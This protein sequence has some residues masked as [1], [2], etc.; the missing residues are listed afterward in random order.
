[1]KHHENGLPPGIEGAIKHILK[2]R[3]KGTIENDCSFDE[4]DLAQDLRLKYLENQQ[5]LRNGNPKA[6]SPIILSGERQGE[7]N[8]NA[9]NHW[10]KQILRE[11][12]GY[13]GAN[14]DSRRKASGVLRSEPRVIR[15]QTDKE[16]SQDGFTDEEILDYV[17]YRRTHPRGGKSQSED[18]SESPPK[19]ISAIRYSPET[20]KEAGTTRPRRVRSDPVD[21]QEPIPRWVFCEIWRREVHSLPQE[22]RAS[23]TTLLDRL[24]NSFDGNHLSI[25]KLAYTLGVPP[26]DLGKARR[27]LR[28]SIQL[29]VGKNAFEALKRAGGGQS[30]GEVRIPFDIYVKLAGPRPVYPD[31]II[32]EAQIT[33]MRIN[34]S[35]AELTTNGEREIS[36]VSFP[37]NR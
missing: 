5:L 20:R 21:V 24:I 10:V 3:W 11:R 22:R 32:L 1:M 23:L 13:H 25:V 9:L 15:A 37:K 7:P 27:V 30:D 14:R 36:L 34:K 29:M 4:E 26:V 28:W 18:D 6:V 19:K 35:D 17:A 8:W 33:R 16:S 31:D 12:Y 2:T